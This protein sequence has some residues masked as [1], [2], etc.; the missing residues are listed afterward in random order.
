MV[1]HGEKLNCNWGI[2]L[3]V[4]CYEDTFIL[5]Y[6]WGETMCRAYSQ[7]QVSHVVMAASHWHAAKV[8]LKAEDHMCNC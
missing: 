3:K 1:P 7:E 6:C 4:L 5:A 8:L 2:S